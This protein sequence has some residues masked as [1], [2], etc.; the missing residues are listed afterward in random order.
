MKKILSIVFILMITIL[1]SAAAYADSQLENKLESL[2]FPSVTVCIDQPYIGSRVVYN[3]VTAST[4]HGFLRIDTGERIYYVGD[5]YGEIINES[6]TYW[7]VAKLFIITKQ[8]TE[9]ILDSAKN[10]SGEYD[11]GSNN[12]IN[13]C[14]DILDSI[15]INNWTRKHNWTLPRDA[16][17]ALEIENL[18]SMRYG[19]TP[20]DAGQDIME[21]WR[22][23]FR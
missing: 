7:N 23:I 2:T 15:G 1:Y 8:D 9:K 21:S 22:F 12:C 19:Y 20:A 18:Y 6:K 5:N 10:Y 11:M 13:F 16:M 17:T 3:P 14:V 4:G